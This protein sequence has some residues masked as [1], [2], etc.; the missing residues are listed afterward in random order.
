M[1]AKKDRLPFEVCDYAANIFGG[2]SGTSMRGFS[3]D[4]MAVFFCKE[5]GKYPEE[6][7]EPS[8]INRR[9]K[10]KWWL[11][12]FDS[13]GS[14][15]RVLEKLCREEQKHPPSY[16]WPSAG[17]RQLLLQKLGSSPI[18]MPDVRFDISHIQQSWEKALERVP[19]DPDGAIT[20]AR[21]LVEDV[22]KHILDDLSV[23]YGRYDDLP[24][25][26]A[27][28]AEKLQ[29]APKQEAPLKRILSGA[30]TVV[31]GLANLRN[32][33]GDAHGKGQNF[34]KPLPHHAEFAVN[35]AGAMATF[36]LRT[37]E[38]NS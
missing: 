12:Q 30:H 20:Q 22:C 37:F 31:D 32:V 33:V 16:W 35:A 1:N 21:T 24:R 11:D 19:S 10:F 7:E 23:S 2:E 6:L 15:R 17:E 26:Y 36:I 34:V 13:A 28:V 5:L 8:Q 27:L 29:I 9:K 3:H 18:E 4:E 25:L 14:Q 38:V